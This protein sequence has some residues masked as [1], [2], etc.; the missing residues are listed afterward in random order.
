MILVVVGGLVMG[1]VGGLWCGGGGGGVMVVWW[2]MWKLFGLSGCVVNDVFVSSWLSVVVVVICFCMLCVVMCF[3]FC[4]V[5]LILMLVCCVRIMIVWL[6]GIGVMWMMCCLVVC[7]GV[8]G[9]KVDR[10]VISSEMVRWRLWIGM[11]FN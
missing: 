11:V 4:L 10:G 6:S 9:E 8:D 3:R 2:M 7:V 1:V 5:L